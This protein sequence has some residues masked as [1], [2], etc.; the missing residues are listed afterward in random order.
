MPESGTPPRLP[1]RYRNRYTQDAHGGL[2]ALRWLP[3]YLLRPWKR[4]DFPV[5]RPDPALLARPE[6]RLTWIGHSSFLLRFAGRSLVT[7]PHLSQRASPFSF[8]GPARLTPP[9]LEH[10]DL[11]PLDLALISHD[12]YDHLDETTV[13]RLAREH[14]RLQFVVPS[15][16]KAWFARRGITRVTELGWWESAEVAGLTVHAVPVQHFS[17]RG[18]HDRN[19][20][21]WCGFMVEGGGQRLFFAGDSGYSKDFQ[22]IAERFAPVDLALLPIGAY[23]PRWFMQHMHMNPEEAVQIHREL[24]CRRSV[25]MHWGTFRL[26]EEPLDEPPQRLRAALAAAGLPAESFWVLE[27][28]ESRALD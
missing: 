9:A 25:A 14:P 10:A 15:G 19:R 4:V 5:R 1:R 12:H 7:D 22:D 2:D 16:L 17:G 27:H 28:G 24:R 13:C 23:D 11:P 18:P 6:P 21:L 26:T 3:G 8:A 20:T